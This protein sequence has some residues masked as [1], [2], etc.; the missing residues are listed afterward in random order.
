MQSDG[1]VGAGVLS[2]TISVDDAVILYDTLV[3]AIFS[4]LGGA[5]SPTLRA[6]DVCTALIGAPDLF[7]R[8]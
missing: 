3:G 7:K 1:M 2:V 5:V 8:S 4:T 6:G